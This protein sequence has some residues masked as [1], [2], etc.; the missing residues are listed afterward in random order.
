MGIKEKPNVV[1]DVYKNRRGRIVNAKI[2]RVFD[3]GTCRA[4]DLLITD[5]NH[6]K[7]NLGIGRAKYQYDTQDLLDVMVEHSGG[8]DDE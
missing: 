6:H 2:Y 4:K 3:Y 8:K 7:W 1:L 5:T